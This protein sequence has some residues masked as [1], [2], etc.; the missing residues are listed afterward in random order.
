MGGNESLETLPPRFLRELT[1]G[2]WQ[3][4]PCPPSFLSEVGLAGDQQLLCLSTASPDPQ[5]R[6]LS[7]VPPE[8]PFNISCWSKNMKD[9]TCR[10]TPG[11][12]GET[13]LHTNYSLKYKLRLV[14]APGDVQRSLAVRHLPSRMLSELS[15]LSALWDCPSEA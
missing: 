9:L 15:V 10:W 8:K 3:H 11:A 4:P 12:H 2:S 6:T 7:S 5:P 14:M 1:Q 13:F